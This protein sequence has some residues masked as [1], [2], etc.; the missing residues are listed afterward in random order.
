MFETDLRPKEIANQFLGILRASI[1]SPEDE[2]PKVVPDA[3]YRSTFLKLT[4]SLAPTPTGERFTQLDIRSA[5]ET[6][7]LTLVPATRTAVSAAIRE[8]RTSSPAEPEAEE[9]IRGVLRGL[10][11]DKDWIE[12][13]VGE[14]HLKINQVGEAVDDVIGPMVNRSVVVRVVKVGERFHFRDIEADE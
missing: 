13:T 8:I 1:E 5:D 6:R 14:D 10:H 7:A 4:R 9:T 12:I 11:L 3:D 2:L